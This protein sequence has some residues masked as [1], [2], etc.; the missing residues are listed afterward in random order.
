MSFP[1]LF[2]QIITFT[3]PKTNFL[4]LACINGE[5]GGGRLFV[6][7]SQSIVRLAKRSAC[8]IGVG[9]FWQGSDEMPGS[10]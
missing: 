4:G 3:T 7:A 8:M 6:A 2:Y 5:G 10:L 9:W 1:A